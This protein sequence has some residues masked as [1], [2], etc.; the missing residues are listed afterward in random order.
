LLF[1]ESLPARWGVTPPRSGAA[2]GRFSPVTC[3]RGSAQ[4]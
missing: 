4:A 2:A 1:A 3:G